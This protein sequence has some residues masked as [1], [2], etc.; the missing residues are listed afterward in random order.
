VQIIHPQHPLAQ[1]TAVLQLSP[2]QLRREIQT[3][4]LLAYRLLIKNRWRWFVRPP[5]E[6]VNSQA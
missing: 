5:V 6:T 4:R 3:G 1:A 2:E